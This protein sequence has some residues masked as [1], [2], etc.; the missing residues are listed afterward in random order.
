VYE[1]AVE[2]RKLCAVGAEAA[3]DELQAFPER[4]A[5][6][7]AAASATTR[8]R[9]VGPLDLLRHGRRRAN[10]SVASQ[11]DPLDAVSSAAAC[12]ETGA[13]RSSLNTWRPMCLIDAR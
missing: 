4:L 7:V 3:A 2:R 1:T 11:T 5:S 12:P 6:D 8:Q 10:A 13:P 9:T